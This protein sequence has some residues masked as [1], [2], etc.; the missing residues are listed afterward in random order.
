MKSAASRS[1]SFPVGTH[2]LN[3]TPNS[4]PCTSGRPWCPLWVT[5]PMRPPRRVGGSGR[6]SKALVLVFG[7]KTRMP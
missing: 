7:P 2:R 6:T 3:A 5:S 1:S 4:V